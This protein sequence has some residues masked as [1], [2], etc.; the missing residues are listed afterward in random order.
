MRS[1]RGSGPSLSHNALLGPGVRSILKRATRNR[2]VAVASGIAVTFMVQS[3]SISTVLY[4]GLLS[5][6]M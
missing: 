6:G 2:F 3:S 4:V 1:L 5:A